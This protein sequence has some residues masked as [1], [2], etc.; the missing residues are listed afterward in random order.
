LASAGRALEDRNSRSDV[1]HVA[2]ENQQQR[3]NRLL[4]IGARLLP[5][6]AVGRDTVFEDLDL[7]KGARFRR[8]LFLIIDAW[9]RSNGDET[10]KGGPFFVSCMPFFTEGPDAGPSGPHTTARVSP[11][12]FARR[13]KTRF[14]RRLPLGP[15]SRHPSFSWFPPFP[16]AVAFASG[17]WA[18]RHMFS[19]KRWRVA[20]FTTRLPASASLAGSGGMHLPG[21]S[22]GPIC[23]STPCS[24]SR[25]AFERTASD[26]SLRHR[27]VTRRIPLMRHLLSD[28]PE[29][30][31][32]LSLGHALGLVD[33]AP[34]LPR[35]GSDCGADRGRL[36][37]TS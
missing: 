36:H 7:S 24:L 17:R 9:I 1:A 11:H 15:N 4:C 13:R 22:P 28:P 16:P 18:P 33:R 14:E 12:A 5:F 31:A 37:P 21:C 25:P 34:S 20:R 32:L 6:R 26:V 2:C 23:C 35:E 8:V 29:H 27:K 3:S 10:R 19:R 30:L